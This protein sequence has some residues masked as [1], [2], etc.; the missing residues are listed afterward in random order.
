MLKRLLI[1]L[2]L[3]LLAISAQ[4]RVDDLYVVGQLGYSASHFGGFNN[5]GFIAERLGIGYNFLTNVAAEIGY[6][7]FRDSTVLNQRIRQYDVD[8]MAVGMIPLL[9]HFVAYS[10][11]GVADMNGEYLITQQPTQRMHSWRFAH[12]MGLRYIFNAYLGA[13]FEWYHV[14]GKA[15]LLADHRGLPIADLYSVQLFIRF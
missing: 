2:C 9:D 4:A 15:G 11:L 1:T 7:H 10:K 12:A 8:M 6:T 14:T 5:R 13:G 3:L